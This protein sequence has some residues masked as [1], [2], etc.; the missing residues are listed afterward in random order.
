MRNLKLKRLVLVSDTKRSAAQFTFDKRFN[1]IT[2]KN[3]NI[4]KSTLIKNIFWV[5]G[6]EPEFDETWIAFDC[7]V[8]L[9]FY[10]GSTSYTVL[11]TNGSIVFG[12]DRQNYQRFNS[13]AGRYSKLF[14]DIV[15]F[16]ARL[17]KSGDETVLECPSP[18]YYFLPFYV[19]QLRNWSNIWKS[20]NNLGNYKEWTKTVIKYHTGYLTPEYFDIEETWFEYRQ[21]KIQ[22]NNEIK[23]IT[24][25]INTV[26]KYSPKSNL[27]ITEEDLE[28]V[29]QEIEVELPNLSEEQ[30]ALVNELTGIEE[31]KYHLNNQRELAKRAAR[32]IEKDYIFAVENIDGDNLEC[33]LC[34]VIHDNS[35]VSRASLLSDKQQAEDQVRLISEEIAALNKKLV[36][37][38]PKLEKTRIRIAEINKKYEKY[39][40]NDSKQ[41]LPEIINALASQS[42]QYNV[43]KTKSEKQALHKEIDDNQKTLRKEQAELSDKEEIKN[44]DEHFSGLLGEFIIKL[45]ALSINLSKVSNPTDYKKLSGNGGATEGA[46]AILAYQLTIFNLIYH[47]KNEIPAPLIIDTPNQ[48]EQA[49]DNYERIMKLIMD[50]TPDQSQIVLCGMDTSHLDRYREQ[51]HV[52]YLD[53]NKLLK[54]EGYAELSN[55]ILHIFESSKLDDDSLAE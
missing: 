42:I 21:Q 39:T 24:T 12:S 47:A 5:L 18:V 14:A 53:D 3:N 4:G 11:R 35:L 28:R 8:L 7:K 38:N 25:T 48:Q 16:K 46:R 15:G 43:E 51:A 36:K 49:G 19:E 40:Q 29:R 6:C 33:P 45:N 27:A 34:G 50:D 1:L 17:V 37:L 9:E 30:E 26:E 32:E 44:L 55:E 22:V 13:I 20:F 54:K 23:E 2:G 31:S 52:I 41:T 10:I